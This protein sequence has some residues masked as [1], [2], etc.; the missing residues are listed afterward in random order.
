MQ[1]ETR[2]KWEQGMSEEMD[3]LIRNKTWDLIEFP[4]GKRELQNKWVYML[5]EE[6]GGKKQYKDRIFVK[7]FVQ[8]KRCIL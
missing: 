2:K 3:S 1:V 4:A 7:G 6:E 8:N 5:K